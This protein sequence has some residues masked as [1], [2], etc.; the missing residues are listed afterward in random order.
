M[1]KIKEA[2]EK[3]KK[4]TAHEKKLK[5]SRRG[6]GAI[7]KVVMEKR[8]RREGRRIRRKHRM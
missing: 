2:E 7:M 3:M 1:G 4:E 6:K 5:E 8:K